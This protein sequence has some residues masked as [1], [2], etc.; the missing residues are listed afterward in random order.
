MSKRIF[1]NN[2][3]SYVS[4]AILKEFRNDKDEEGE[5]N[6][7]ANM[8]FGTYVDKDHTEKPDGISKMLKVGHIY[9]LRGYKTLYLHY[10]DLNRDL[11]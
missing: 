2:L 5:E 3:N 4:Q 1:I 6:P 11:P 9:P 7:D 10:R 8:L